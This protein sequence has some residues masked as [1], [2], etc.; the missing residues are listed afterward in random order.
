[1]RG[2][3]GKIKHFYTEEELNNSTFDELLQDNFID[4]T[5]YR[6][7]KIRSYAQEEINK[8]VPMKKVQENISEIWNIGIQAVREILYRGR[9]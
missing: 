7:N 4:R 9:K 1:M 6:N 5:M 2:R 3:Q 8:G